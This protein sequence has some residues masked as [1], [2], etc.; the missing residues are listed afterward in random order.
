MNAIKV[1]ALALIVAG[2]MAL[3]YGGFSYT[4][5][6]QAIKLGPVAV[7]VDETHVVN[8]PIWVGLGALVLGGALLLW[9]TRR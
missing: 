9:G 2:L 7:T 5:R 8:V 1:M 4:E 3:A 6:S